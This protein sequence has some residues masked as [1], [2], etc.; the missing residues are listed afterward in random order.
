MAH[1]GALMVPSLPREAR[2]TLALSTLLVLAAVL[3][4]AWLVRGWG[5]AGWRDWY[6][7]LHYLLVVGL[8]LAVVGQLFARSRGRRVWPSR[9]CSPTRSCASSRRAPGPTSNSS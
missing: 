3:H 4:S 9:G 7:D 8:F 2:P 6:S 5:G 1:S